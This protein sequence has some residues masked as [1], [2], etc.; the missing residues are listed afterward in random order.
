MSQN[1]S[2]RVCW[3][4]LIGLTLLMAAA[5]VFVLTPLGASECQAADDKTILIGVPAGFT[6]PE[7]SL[8]ADWVRGLQLAI[9]EINANGGASG[10]KLKIVKADIKDA[11]PDNVL[12]AVNKLLSNKDVHICITGWA[13]LTAFEVED[14]ARAEMP[15][16]TSG[17]SIQFK[18]IVEKDPEKYITQYCYDPTFYGYQT[19]PVNR[20]EEW[21]EEGLWQIKKNKTV[22]MITSDVPYSL[23]IFNGLT[24][25]FEERGW[26]ITVHDTVP[27][28]RIL[29]W[30]AFLGKVRS[31][32]PDVVINTDYL[33]SNA[34]SFTEQFLEDPTNSVLFIQYGPSVPEYLDLVGNKSTGIFY[35][36]ISMPLPGPHRDHI[37][38]LYKEKYPNLEPD[39]YVFKM[40]DIVYIYADAL[41]KVG[42][43][44]KHIEIGRANGQTDKEVVMGRLRFHPQWHTGTED[45]VDP[46][47]GFVPTAFKQIWEGK[48]YILY[49]YE[50]AEAKFRLPPWIKY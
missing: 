36:L 40:Y 1:G 13:S 15:Y 21:A 43:P 10:Y 46:G 22:A 28:G 41:K 2:K 47:Q 17:A 31:N 4:R 8:A 24:K 32:P 33:P 18:E 27:G 44:A 16:V 5:A 29:D 19:E 38:K 37:Y 48:K 14:M 42:D 25:T 20:L 26:T 7:A 50:I 30:T 39:L 23:D 49:P 35:D 45:W 34:A 9:D 11:K 12:S 6:G 3:G